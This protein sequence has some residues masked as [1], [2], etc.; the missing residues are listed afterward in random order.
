MLTAAHSIRLEPLC[1]SRNLSLGVN[2][3]SSVLVLHLRYAGILPP[4]HATSS[5]IPLPHHASHSLT[6]TWIDSI[7][8]SPSAPHELPP[9]FLFL[10]GPLGDRWYKLAYGDSPTPP[11]MARLLDEMTSNAEP[12]SNGNLGD[13]PLSVRFQTPHPPGGAQGARASE[14]RQPCSEKF[15]VTIKRLIAIKGASA[16]TLNLSINGC[17]PWHSVPTPQRGVSGEGELDGT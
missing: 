11:A 16:T 4:R 12:S 6:L 7:P 17:I 14:C 2:N 10:T 13:L 8:S 15:Q 5:C 1:C 3:T 9:R